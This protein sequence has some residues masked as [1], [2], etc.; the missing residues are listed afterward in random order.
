MHR[1]SWLL[2]FLLLVG[3]GGDNEG[4]DGAAPPV[5]GT[6]VD[7]VVEGP[8]ADGTTADGSSV[9]GKPQIVTPTLDDSDVRARVREM[10]VADLIASL[11]DADL[12]DAATDELSARGADAVKPLID[13]LESSDAM[14]Q[15][16]AIFTLGRIGPTAKD[17]LPK[18]NELAAESN[19]EMIRDSAKFAIDA[20]EGN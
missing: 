18:L 15:Q 14:A 10:K 1:Y 8:A 11:S 9:D 16:R 20:I 6:D 7:V 13:A 17:A 12:S 2:P 5:D 3:C 19:S 4:T